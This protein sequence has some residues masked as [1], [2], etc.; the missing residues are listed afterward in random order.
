M[1]RVIVIPADLAAP[2]R[3][4]HPQ[5]ELPLPNAEFNPAE[6]AAMDKRF[7]W[8]LALKERAEHE[9]KLRASELGRQTAGQ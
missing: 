8:E 7:T 6:P 1:P 4:P 9:R 2:W 5:M 3:D